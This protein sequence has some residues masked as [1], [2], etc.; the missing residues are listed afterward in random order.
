MFKGEIHNSYTGTQRS[1]M[2]TKHTSI[3]IFENGTDLQLL[4]EIKEKRVCFRLRNQPEI[5][6]IEIDF[7]RP[8]SCGSFLIAPRICSR[9]SGSEGA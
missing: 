1:H 8:K 3:R 5:C 6:K 2:N 7:E 4:N 9:A